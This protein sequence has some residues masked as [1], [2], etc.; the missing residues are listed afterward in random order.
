M[1]AVASGTGQRQRRG[2]RSLLLA[3]L[4]TWSA[5]VA[6]AE[7]AAAQEPEASA[8]ST[9][10]RRVGPVE[11]AVFGGVGGLVGPAGVSAAFL[12]LPRLALGLALGRVGLEAEIGDAGNGELRVAPF[13]PAMSS[14]GPRGDWA[15]A[16]LRRTGRRSCTTLGRPMTARPR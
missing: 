14:I 12:P 13:V 15:W 16:S 10:S 5:N 11:L 2:Q 1:V 9:S 4:L 8:T 3:A 6:R 7:T